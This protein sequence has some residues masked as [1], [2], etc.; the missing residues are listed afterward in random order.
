MANNAEFEEI[1]FLLLKGHLPNSQELNSYKTKLKKLRE[2]PSELKSV[3]EQIPS[4][5]H[6]MDV[7]RT[8]C[9]MLGCL[10][11]EESFS[12]EDDKIDR[13]LALFPSIISYWYRYSHDKVRIDTVTDDDTIGAHFL[14]LVHDEKPSDLYTK[15]MNVS[16]ILY[17]E[18]EFNASTFA[19]RVCASTLSDLHSCIT[20]AIGTLRLSLIHI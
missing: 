17:A 14:R 1:A 16:L 8:G 15:V 18:H 2:I 4:N 6:P 10:E 9:S 13:M 7:M 19:A 20:A 11:T 3:L 5:S 12:E